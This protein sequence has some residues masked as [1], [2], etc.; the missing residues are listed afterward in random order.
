MLALSEAFTSGTEPA[1]TWTT[2]GA[3]A[4][5]SWYSAHST[6]LLVANGALYLMYVV[7]VRSALVPH[8]LA[9]F[10]IAATVTAIAAIAATL[11]GYDFL[12]LS[13]APL[14]VRQLALIFWLLARGLSNGTHAQ[15]ASVTSPELARA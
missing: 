7:L 14:G 15:L 8:V 3:L 2:M 9:G 6:N 1:P 11:L 4:R 13:M 10:G 12:L 5:S